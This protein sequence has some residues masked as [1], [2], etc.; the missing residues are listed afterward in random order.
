MP[1][2]EEEAVLRLAEAARRMDI[3]P[4]WRGAQDDLFA[5]VGLV[6]TNPAWLLFVP[7]DPEALSYS[8]PTT[9]LL[10]MTRS[11]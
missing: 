11:D 6:S 1:P 4:D 3:D 8:E 5:A 2:G 10:L 9:T 7:S